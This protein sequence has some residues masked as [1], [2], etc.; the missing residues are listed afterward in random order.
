MGMYDYLGKTQVKCFYDPIVEHDLKDF[1][2]LNLGEITSLRMW[3]TTGSLHEYK[4]MQM[5]PWKTMWYDYGKRFMV[6][7]PDDVE[8]AGLVHIIWGGRYIHS[9]HYSKL[10]TKI[11]PIGKVISKAGDELNITTKNQFKEILDHKKSLNNTCRQITKAYWED[12]KNHDKD[13]MEAMRELDEKTFKVRKLF[14]DKW[15]SQDRDIQEGWIIGAFLYGLYGF[16]EDDETARKYVKFL[17]EYVGG[18][19]ALEDEIDKYALWCAKHEIKIYH[20]DLQMFFMNFP[21]FKNLE[22]LIKTNLWK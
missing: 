7:D 17:K 2:G 11:F 19:E 13:S 9:V 15:V 16:C 20:A 14:N 21:T 5:V 12:P 6:F 3:P 10:N 1:P 22:K 8:G 4:H 18:D